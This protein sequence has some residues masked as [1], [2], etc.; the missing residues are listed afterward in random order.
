MH[1]CMYVCMDVVCVLL[2]F[3]GSCV[4]MWV[5]GMEGE[6]YCKLG[7]GIQGKGRKDTTIFYVLQT[8]FCVYT[9]KH[10]FCP[11]FDDSAKKESCNVWMCVCL[12]FSSRVLISSSYVCFYPSVLLS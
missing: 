10:G 9:R 7:K 1:V 2:C 5:Y 3:A 6:G 12:L 4:C 8:R 11:I